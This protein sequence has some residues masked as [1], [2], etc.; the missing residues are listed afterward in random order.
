[1]VWLSGCPG[2]SGSVLETSSSLNCFNP[3]ALQTKQFS[4]ANSV[5]PDKMAN[6][7]RLYRID[8]VCRSVIDF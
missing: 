7:S 6:I 5:D 8:I 4:F 2:L 1:M 3:S